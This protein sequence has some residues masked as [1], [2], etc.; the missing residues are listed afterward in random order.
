MEGKNWSYTITEGEHKGVTLWSGRYTAVCGIVIGMRDDEPG[1]RYILANKRGE[2][3]PD[4]NGLW[5]L[6]CGFLEADENGQQG[7]AR[8]IHEECGILI[9]WEDF[10]YYSNETDPAKCNNGN[11]TLRYLTSVVI[12]DYDDKDELSGEENE[13]EDVKWI[14]L[15][16]YENYEWAFNHK[17]VIEE[18]KGKYDLIDYLNNGNHGF[19]AEEGE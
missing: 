14:P 6:P 16:E 11:V 17:E 7:V 10:T 5:N 9:P 8:E 3:C 12:D 19:N 2:G 13:V 18:I 1:K 4:Y 15:N